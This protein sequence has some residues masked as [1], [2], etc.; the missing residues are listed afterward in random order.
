MGSLNMNR[1]ADGFGESLIQ[2]RPLDTG[3]NYCKGGFG[4]LQEASI[5]S[6]VRPNVSGR[7]KIARMEVS[8]AALALKN[9]IFPYPFHLGGFMSMSPGLG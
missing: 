5:S 9:L 1:D 3:F 8:R 7:Q 6:F 4:L 2:K